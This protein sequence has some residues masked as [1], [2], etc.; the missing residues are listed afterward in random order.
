MQPDVEI[1]DVGDITADVWS[2]MIGIEAEPVEPWDLFPTE[3]RITSA[4]TISGT[5][6]GTVVLDFDMGL[7]R[8]AAGAM[9]ELEIPEVTD[10]ELTDAVGELANMVGGSIKSLLEEPCKLGLPTVAHGGEWGEAHPE[11]TLFMRLGFDCEGAPMRVSL[12]ENP[13]TEAA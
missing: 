2:S 13:S 10:E 5:W 1:E 12:W 11:V 9:F 6:N 8:R 3:D 4:V 7:A